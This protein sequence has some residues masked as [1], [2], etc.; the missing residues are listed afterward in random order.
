MEIPISAINAN[1][2]FGYNW[3]QL[4]LYPMDE[5]FEDNQVASDNTTISVVHDRHL[6]TGGIMLL[7]SK[8]IA[9]EGAY[10]YSFWKMSSTDPDYVNALTESHVAQ[11]GIV[12]LT[13]R[14]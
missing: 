7:L 6:I 12:S 9:L 10:G 1:L 13:M 11:R 3:Q 8:S 4:D 14:Y 5:Q 2:R